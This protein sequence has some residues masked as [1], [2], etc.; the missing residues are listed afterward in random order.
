M[1]PHLLHSWPNS[2]KWA[3]TLIVALFTFVSPVC[4]SLIAPGGQQVA[5]E[6]G[7]TSN[8]II[9]MITSIFI[10]GYGTL[11]LTISCKPLTSSSHWTAGKLIPRI[12]YKSFSQNIYSSWGH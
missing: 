4:S 8:L 5:D 10:L 2:R 12:E 1:F 11:I 9:N 7:I 3:A 6:F